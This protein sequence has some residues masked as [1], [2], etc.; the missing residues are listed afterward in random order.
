MLAR[1]E[2]VALNGIEGI[3]VI[4]ETDIAMGLPYFAIIGLGDTAVKEASERVRRAVI[5]SGFKY[6]QGRIT[7]NLSPAYVYKK[8]SH[9]DLG[10]AAGILAAEGEVKYNPAGR[11]FI[12]ELSLSGEV[13]PV[14]GVLPM[15]AS[16]VEAG[17]NCSEVLLPV[18]NCAEAYLV[19]KDSRLKLIP[20]A[21]LR[22]AI[23]HL[24]GD[25]IAAYESNTDVSNACGEIPD[26]ADVKGHQAAKSAIACAMA[27]AHSIL[28]L[29]SPGTGKTML[30]RRVPGILPPMELAEKL[31]TTKIYSAAGQLSSEMPIIADRPFRRLANGITTAQLLGG[32]NIP[33]PGE[34]SFAHKGVLFAD[35]FLELPRSVLESLRKPMEEKSVRIV[36]RGMTTLFPAD[37][38]LVCASNPCKCGFLGDTK[39]ECT[40]TQ[41]E[42]DNYR[43]RLSGPLA[44]RIDM[45]VEL[46]RVNYQELSGEQTETTEQIRKRVLR[47][48]AIQRERF[49]G[50]DFAC[51]SQMGEAQLAEFC[52]LGADESEFMQAAYETLAISPRRY[53]KLLKL[54]R[55][56]ADM[57]ES[58]YIKQVH[59]AAAIHFTRLLNNRRE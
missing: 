49:A 6:P 32:G 48:R 23:G 59:L 55:T 14:K 36:R 4:I 13:L 15:I 43:S 41:S 28:L 2:S 37:F 22:D 9:Y 7:V 26:F 40:C 38:I 30:A 45:C 42:I 47:A 31:E 44:D 1:T 27:G 29:G 34:I 25:S 20:V 58:A 5:N 57:E 35:E 8:G 21:T 52:R 46:C 17:S 39:H 54:A 33:M 50:L 53:H 3:K 11:I 51:N 56:L 12:G 24:E 16:A 19:T 10:I 18:S